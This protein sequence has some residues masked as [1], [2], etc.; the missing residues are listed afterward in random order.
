M[1]RSKIADDI[2]MEEHLKQVF[3]KQKIQ[4][5]KDRSCE[6]CKVQK[7]CETKNK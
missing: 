1:V 3:S 7:V 5:C 2:A 6:K 4:K